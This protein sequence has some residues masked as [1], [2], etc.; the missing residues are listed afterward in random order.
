[1]P[2]YQFQDGEATGLISAAEAALRHAVRQW[3]ETCQAGPEAFTREQ[4]LRLA[5]ISREVVRLC[6]RAVEG[7]LFATAG[8]SSVR[9]GDRIERVWR[10]MSPPHNPARGGRFPFPPAHPGPRPAPPRPRSPA[11]VPPPPP[12]H[13]QRDAPP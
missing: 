12:P 3:S 13:P 11:P 5:L 8:S 1:D 9:H 4:E 6:W 10:G 2:D 7:H